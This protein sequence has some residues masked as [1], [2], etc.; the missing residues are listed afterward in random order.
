[1]LIL[2]NDVNKIYEPSLLV[3]YAILLFIFYK[4]QKYKI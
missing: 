4:W 2:N 3:F 1:M